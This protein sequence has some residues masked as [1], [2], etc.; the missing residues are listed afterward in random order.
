MWL[1]WVFLLLAV[2]CLVLLG[3]SFGLAQ[4][5]LTSNEKSTERCMFSAPQPED[6]VTIEIERERFLPRLHCTYV[7]HQGDRITETHRLWE[8]WL[9]VLGPAAVVLLAIFGIL[10]SRRTR[11]PIGRKW[12]PLR[13][14]QPNRR[15]SAPRELATH[16][17]CTS[18]FR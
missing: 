6:V 17:P 1:R 7:T 14:I 18:F 9:Y 15:V 5:V 3:L 10:T 13:R 12:E 16:R 2:A 11:N 8:Q 4:F